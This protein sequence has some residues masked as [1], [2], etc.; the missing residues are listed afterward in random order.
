V[1]CGG[2]DWAKEHHDVEPMDPAGRRLS[3]ARLSEGVAGIARLHAMIG[4]HLGRDAEADQAVIGTQTDHSPWMAALIAAGYRVFA[5]KSAA[6]GPLPRTP[7]PVGGQ[8]RRR[9]RW[10][11]WSLP[12]PTSCAPWPGTARRPRRS[13]WSPAPIRG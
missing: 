9:G 1:L 13:R 5:I 2:D 10:P 8:K 3:R 12:T 11:P 6:G 7:Q 4:E